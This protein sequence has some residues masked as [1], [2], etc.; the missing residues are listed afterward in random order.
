MVKIEWKPG[1]CAAEKM[2]ERYKNV[3][4]MMINHDIATV[5]EFMFCKVRVW[6]GNFYN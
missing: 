4:H 5:R 2:Q 6:K 3:D 1:C